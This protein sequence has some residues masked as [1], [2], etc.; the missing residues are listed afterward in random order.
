[1]EPCKICNQKRK[2]YNFG[3]IMI[4]LNCK[5]RMYLIRNR[6]KMSCNFSTGQTEMFNIMKIKLFYSLENL[7]RKT[8]L[9][10]AVKK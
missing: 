9:K 3:S 8:S 10:M 7:T 4:C 5:L 6:L 2:I 1:M